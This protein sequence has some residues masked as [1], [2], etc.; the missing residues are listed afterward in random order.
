MILAPTNKRVIRPYDKP[1]FEHTQRYGLIRGHWANTN[2]VGFW[3]FNEGSGNI[4]QDLSGYGNTGTASGTHWVRGDKVHALQFD[5]I[6]DSVNCGSNTSLFCGGDEITIVVS[7]RQKPGTTID[8][9][10]VIVGRASSVGRG[11]RLWTRDISAFKY[12]FEVKDATDTTWVT[13]TT[14]IS[15]TNYQQ[16]VGVCKANSFMRLYVNGVEEDSNLALANGWSDE[17]PFSM[18]MMPV[19]RRYFP[20]EL[21]YLYVFNRISSASEIAQLYWEPLLGVQREPRITY[22]FAPIGGVVYQELNLTVIADA[23]V[24]ETDTQQMID[25]GKE[26]SADAIASKSDTQQMVETGKAV[27]AAASVSC[28]DLKVIFE[29]N[30]TVT[31]AGSVIATD[32]HTMIETGKSVTAVASPAVIDTQ[33]MVETELGV[34][35]D[36]SVSCTDTMGLLA[37]IAAFMILRQCT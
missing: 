6:N 23:N 7:L 36:A 20:M 16:V 12:C 29:L 19:D 28:T 31:A 37:H 4:V 9:Y 1:S 30:L 25:T 35:A 17:T 18:G 24:A 2:R 5:G 15:S 26:V 33:A 13:S 32:E 14:E 10:D 34:S 11:Y 3:P 21:E 27:Q 22:F 8:Q